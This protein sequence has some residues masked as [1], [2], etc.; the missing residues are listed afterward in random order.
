MK[1]N[2]IK[3]YES[4]FLFEFITFFCL[5]QLGIEKKEIVIKTVHNYIRIYLK[6]FRITPK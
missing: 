2:K 6:L 1:K 5:A 4:I 3:F